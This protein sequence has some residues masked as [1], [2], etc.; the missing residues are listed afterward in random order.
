MKDFDT[1]MVNKENIFPYKNI[2]VRDVNYEITHQIARGHFSTI[3]EATDIWNNNLVA[4]VYD[5]R[6][7]EKI[8]ENEITQLKKFS[9]LNVVSLYEAFSYD[10]FHILIMENFGVSISRVRTNDFDTKIKI[11]LECAK[12]LLQTL[13]NIHQSGYIHSDINPH[14]LLIKIVNNQLLGV[15]LCDFSFCRNI[16]TSHKE[17]IGIADWIMP[18]ECFNEGYDKLTTAIDVY[19]AALV[20]FSILN[21]EKLSYSNEEILSNK[22]QLDVLNSNISLVNALAPALEMNPN[23]RI[24]VMELW[25]NLVK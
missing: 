5:K 1:E 23:K 14:N 19:H 20:L 15:K 9:S 13:F 8:F 11:F 12:S 10:N 25:E 3:Y 2:E 18:P 6:I 16:N 17:L 22:P 7:N 24:S 4:K 21:E